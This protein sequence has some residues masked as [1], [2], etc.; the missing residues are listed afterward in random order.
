MED[1]RK[2]VLWATGIIVALIVVASVMLFFSMTSIEV[3]T[4]PVLSTSTTT[5]EQE[6][7]AKEIANYEGVVSA[8]QAQRTTTYDFVVVKTLLPL[9]NSLIA[10]VLTYVFANTALQAFK[11]YMTEKYKRS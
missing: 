7:K 5:S 4:T 2:I 3:P 6:A 11:T 9:F 1:V 10:S 8:L